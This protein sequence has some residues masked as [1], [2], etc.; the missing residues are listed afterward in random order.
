MSE[1]LDGFG[2]EFTEMIKENIPRAVPRIQYTPGERQAKAEIPQH[3]PVNHP[4][5]YTSGGI[6]VIDFIEAKKFNYNLGN[7][8]K[9]ISRSGL[10]GNKKQ[11]LE[12]AIW[13]LKR[14]LDHAN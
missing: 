1:E 12:K 4:S 11:D 10:K 8:V 13:Y 2:P 9:Y 5:H 3:D 6:E 14:E 7:A